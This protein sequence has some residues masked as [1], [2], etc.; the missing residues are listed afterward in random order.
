MNPLDTAVREV[1]DFS[2]ATVEVLEAQRLATLADV[3]G[4]PPPSDLHPL[5]FDN[6]QAIFDDLGF[7]WPLS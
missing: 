1:E 6:I 4:W 7:D 3:L 5:V 2:I